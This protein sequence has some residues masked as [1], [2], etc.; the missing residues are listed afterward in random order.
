MMASCSCNPAPN[1]PKVG[2]PASHQATCVRSPR[3]PNNDNVTKIK[4]ASQTIARNRQCQQDAHLAALPNEANEAK[5][6]LEA[7]VPDIKINRII[8]GLRE[9]LSRFTISEEMYV[10]LAIIVGRDYRT[11]GERVQVV[12]RKLS[13][14]RNAG[15]LRLHTKL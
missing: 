1:Q 8:R 5:L 7:K 6:G 2:S 11:N 4:P 14:W 9:M 12:Q 13:Q 3:G 15:T 10:E